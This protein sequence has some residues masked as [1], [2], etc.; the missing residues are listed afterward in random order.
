MPHLTQDPVIPRGY[1]TVP[2]A[3]VYLGLTEHAIR[4]RI[5]RNEVPYRRWHGRV[6]L[7]VRE[8]D[9]FMAALDGCGVHEALDHVGVLP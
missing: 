7:I 9:A 1:L 2:Q 3:A 8:L 4:Q 6:V 5:A